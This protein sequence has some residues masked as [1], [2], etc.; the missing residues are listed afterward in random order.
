MPTVQI[1]SRRLSLVTA[2]LQ[3]LVPLAWI[4]IATVASMHGDPELPGGPAD[5]S[6]L[7]LS[8]K[9]AF[10]VLTSIAPLLLGL[11]LRELH[12]LLLLYAGGEVFTAPA[13]V[14]IHRMGVLLVAY[15]LAD[16]VAFLAA[17]LVLYFTERLT[18]V[19]LVYRLHL[20]ELF[21]GLVVILLG[22]IMGMACRM[23]DELS[24]T[25]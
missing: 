5:A 12:Q 2:V 16:Q 14:R 9:I 6:Q 3:W 19:P 7:Q 25:V 10:V 18:E 8:S 1:Y 23:Q 20:G 15:S 4:A 24:L 21:I 11:M 17:G 13:V 22:R